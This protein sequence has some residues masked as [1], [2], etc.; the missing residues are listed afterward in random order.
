MNDH[1]ALQ[2]V[3]VFRQKGNQVQILN[4]PVTVSGECGSK[5]AIVPLRA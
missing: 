5:K 3:G 1:A 2:C 4:D